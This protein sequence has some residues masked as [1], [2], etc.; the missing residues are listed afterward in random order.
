[1]AE[2]P[3][4]MHTVPAGYLRAFA[5]QSVQRRKPHVWQFER[6]GGDGRLIS[7]RDAAVSRGIY[8][9]RSADGVADTTIET[10]LLSP[11]VDDPFPAVVRL[12]CGGGTPTTWQWRDLSRFAAFQ[13]ARTPRIFQ[14]F[15]DSGR[16]HGVAMSG[17]DPALAMVH[18]APFLERWLCRM[19]WTLYENHATLPLLASDNPAVLWSDR[20]EGAELGTG[21]A[22][23]ALRV[24]LPLT[25]RLCL[26][27][28]HNAVSLQTVHND[29]PDTNPQFS[30]RHQL[31]I[32]AG[33]LGID[34]T[35]RLN[36]VTVANAERYVYANSRDEKVLLFLK[37]LF[38]GGPGPVRR[39][40]RKPV[41]S[42]VD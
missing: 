9:L 19:T 2:R 41:G 42:P 37:D 18:Q 21:F 25:P 12:L 30:D 14:I 16:H 6:A 36:Q 31:F 13:L 23:P 5:D 40:D 1:M 15:R 24:L 4:H 29:R 35:V 27:F 10:S 3:E 32:R 7:V 20:G 39:F 8:T 11:A 28:S 22:D 17:N 26:M 34:E 38:F 33:R